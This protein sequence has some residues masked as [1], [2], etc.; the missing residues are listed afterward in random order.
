MTLGYDLKFCNCALEYLIFY[1]ASFD[2]IPV[3]NRIH[4]YSVPEW[5]Q[6]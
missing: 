6:I 3:F 4:L 2:K 5:K 1:E